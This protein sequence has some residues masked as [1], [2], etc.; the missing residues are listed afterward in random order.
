MTRINLS[1]FGGNR[2]KN[3]AV[4]Q[5]DFQIPVKLEKRDNKEDAIDGVGH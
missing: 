3:I 1:Y 5:T 4:V 2:R